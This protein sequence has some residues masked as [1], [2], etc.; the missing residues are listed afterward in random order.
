MTFLMN[1]FSL[2][3]PPTVV[4][5]MAVIDLSIQSAPVNHIHPVAIMSVLFFS[6]VFA[7]FL[8]YYMSN[9]RPIS[10]Y[11]NLDVMCE[12]MLVPKCKVEDTLGPP[13]KKVRGTSCQPPICSCKADPGAKPLMQSFG[14]VPKCTAEDDAM[15]LPT[16]YIHFE[17]CPKYPNGYNTLLVIVILSQ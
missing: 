9:K 12:A 13:S 7:N 3:P 2:F 11:C 5:T 17:G 14:Q 8:E 1:T 4:H 15:G 6:F 16:K 10:C